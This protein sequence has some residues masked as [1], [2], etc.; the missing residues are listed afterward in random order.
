MNEKPGL[1]GMIE[2]KGTLTDI[3][4]HNRDSGYTVAVIDTGEEQLTVIGTL[5]YCREG[6]TYIL[7]GD[8][9]VHPN[10]GEQFAFSEF[11]EDM[12]TTS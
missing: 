10:Y 6:N 12:P 11:E 3:I 8:M 5:P 4:F 7:R 2:K 9:K 1:D